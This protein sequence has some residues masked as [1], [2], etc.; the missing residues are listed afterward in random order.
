MNRDLLPYTM[1]L[2]FGVERFHLT[3]ALEPEGFEVVALPPYDPFDQDNDNCATKG[4]HQEDSSQ[5]NKKSKTTNST[6]ATSSFSVFLAPLQVLVRCS[7]RLLHLA[8]GLCLPSV[9]FS[10]KQTGNSKLLLHHSLRVLNQGRVYRIVLLLN[11]W[12]IMAANK[13]CSSYA[14]SRNLAGH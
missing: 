14:I 12:Q 9:Y 11:V 4:E 7:Y 1:D 8:R 2:V 6:N 5:K 10:A 3:F 13:E